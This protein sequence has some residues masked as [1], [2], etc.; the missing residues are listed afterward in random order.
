M[1]FQDISVFNSGGH[2][3]SRAEQNSLCNFVRGHNEEHFCEIIL[4]SDQ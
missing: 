2:F 3:V 4:T 1:T